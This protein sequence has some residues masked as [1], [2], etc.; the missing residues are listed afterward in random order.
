MRRND[1]E[2]IGVQKKIDK[3]IKRVIVQGLEAFVC[4][5]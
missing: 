4:S 5:G 1:S 2:I 3:H